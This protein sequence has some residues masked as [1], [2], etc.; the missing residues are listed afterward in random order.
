MGHLT[1]L[2]LVLG[3]QLPELA[4]AAAKIEQFLR[5]AGV[6]DVTV[7]QINLAVEE[8]LT[9]TIKYGH[10][11][12]QPHP[13]HVSLAIA[14]GEIVVEIEDDA[15]PFDPFARP[16]VDTAAPLDDRRPGGLGLHIVKELIARVA[17]RRDAGRNFVTLQQPFAAMEGGPS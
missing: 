15:A 9:N 7:L 2:S 6:P 14:G 13:I 8:L 3:S 10:G 5:D 17:Y 1:N 16:P 4:G 11:D 12:G